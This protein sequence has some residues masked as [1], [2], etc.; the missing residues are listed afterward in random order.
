MNE[1]TQGVATGHRDS[2][3]P[4][5]STPP[6]NAAGLPGSFSQRHD[7]ENEVIIY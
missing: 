5:T 2:T 1:G 7:E 6:L 3:N 4:V